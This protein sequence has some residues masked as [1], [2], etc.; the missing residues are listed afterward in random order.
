MISSD[1]SI[2][3]CINTWL[4]NHDG[5]PSKLDDISTSYDGPTFDDFTWVADSF[6]FVEVSQ[7]IARS[8]YHEALLAQFFELLWNIIVLTFHLLCKIMFEVGILIKIIAIRV[9]N[10][11]ERAHRDL[12]VTWF[13]WSH[14]G[15]GIFALSCD[16]ASPLYFKLTMFIIVIC[17]S[18]IIFFVVCIILLLYHFSAV[19]VNPYIL[20]IENTPL[21]VFFVLSINLYFYILVDVCALL[22]LN[23]HR[24]QVLL[25]SLVLELEYV[26]FLNDWSNFAC[27]L[28]CH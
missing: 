24:F 23:R 10:D 3:V 13:L 12:V 21:A 11:R 9:L 4:L 27:L 16:V 15:H 7:R 19:D 14:W 22:T 8:N 5:H 1:C 6:A 20:K 17:A 28:L 2:S 26:I 18:S 25:V